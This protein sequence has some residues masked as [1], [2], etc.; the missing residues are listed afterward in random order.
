MKSQTM[1]VADEE[2]TQEAPTLNKFKTRLYMYRQGD[3]MERPL[4]RFVFT[5]LSILFL[6][7]ETFELCN[8]FR[9][10]SFPARYELMKRS[11]KGEKSGTN[12]RW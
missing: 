4:L 2:P 12:E 8:S 7:T 9:L 5:L 11:K 6:R 1:T 3:N 10:V